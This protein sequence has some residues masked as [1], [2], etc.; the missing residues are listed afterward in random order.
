[1]L[2]R[3]N[4]F[5][6]KRS[7]FQVTAVSL[8]LVVALAAIDHATGYEVA[9]SI[10]YLVPITLATWYGRL[11]QSILLC[12]V[13]AIAWLIVDRTAGHNYSQAFIPFW[14]AG[15]R[16]GFFIVTARLL[17]MVRSQLEK[18]RQM[19]RLDGLTG[20]M[21]GH[22]FEEAA[23][24][25]LRIAARYGRPTVMG[26]IDLDNFKSVNDT[27]GHTEGDHVIRTVASILSKSIRSADL[28]GRL[29]GDEFAILLPETACSGAATMFEHLREGLLKEARER[30]WPI[31]FSIGVAVFRTAPSSVDE[32]IK[33]ADALMYRVK[34]GGKNNILL[35]E[36]GHL[37]E[38][39]QQPN[40]E[41]LRKPRG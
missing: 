1:M 20:V 7:S 31:G 12:I 29:G 13:S 10:F 8:V 40:G 25:I 24:T 27:L 21:N 22:A 26:Y 34:N 37:E 5:L 19:A 23:Q 9:F 2:A 15:I 30:V 4:A 36:F 16:L 32:A 39:G 41:R 14:N 33:L 17:A 35:E 3:L 38:I 11:P 28:I 18:E 6:K